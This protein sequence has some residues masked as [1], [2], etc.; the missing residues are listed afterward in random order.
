MYKQEKDAKN[1]IPRGGLLVTTSQPN[2]P[3]ASRPGLQ[4]PLLRQVDS[5][6]EDEEDSNSPKARTRQ[7]SVTTPP[8]SANFI[9]GSTA[10]ARSISTSSGLR[11]N[12][13]TTTRP[14]RTPSVSSPPTAFTAAK[15]SS[16]M[17][18]GRDFKKFNVHDN[19]GF[20]ART[21]VRQR[22][23]DSLDLDDIMNGSD[24]DEEEAPAHQHQKPK[25]HQPITP[26]SPK[27]VGG[28]SSQTRDLMDF[29]AEG[30]PEPPSG[31]GGNDFVDFLAS[32]PPEQIDAKPK[33]TGRLQRMIS[34][35][36]LGNEK[37]KATQ[38]ARTTVPKP[39]LPP[40]VLPTPPR[41][42]NIAGPSTMPLA[43]RPI[44]P[45][46]PRPISPPSSPSM[47]HESSDENKSFR[48]APRRPY[49]DTSLSREASFSTS[50]RTASEKPTAYPISPVSSAGPV[51]REPSEKHIPTDSHTPSG[52]TYTPGSSVSGH[53]Y[54]TPTGSGYATPNNGN[55][56][57]GHVS[58]N[59]VPH[60]QQSGR[61]YHNGSV[62][63]RDRPLKDVLSDSQTIVPARS[64][65]YA[66]PARKP[67][68]SISSSR[69]S[70]APSPPP[71]FAYAPPSTSPTPPVQ[72]GRPNQQHVQLIQPPKPPKSAARVQAPLPPEPA[73][74]VISESDI[75]DM[76]RLL[77][78]AST[79]D[80]CRLIFD[81]YLARNKIPR[82]P[83]VPYP[84]PSPSVVK[85]NTH[86]EKSLETSVVE[87]FLGG[88][89]Q[90]QPS[91]TNTEQASVEGLPKSA[92]APSE[93]SAQYT[94][95]IFTPS[96]AP[97]RHM[98]PIPA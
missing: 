82:E 2:P 41:L 98:A 80:E 14:T 84:S 29:L 27:K 92:L 44:P 22:N 1:T 7:V 70:P 36:N 61:G 45:R 71:A 49:Q 28:V 97:S 19:N 50:E 81:M 26:M 13:L 75:R 16:D 6:N 37:A 68:P 33:G 67:V 91:F 52:N 85:A 43:N 9:P 12:P 78:S 34:K 3:L 93:Q 32:G 74:S 57:P 94:A 40:A 96:P 59:G 38:D 30:P 54:S 88:S 62:N 17:S 47:S 35:L 48:N 73:S 89:R 5:I 4:Q 72:Q 90:Q 42:P 60:G 69:A 64:T 20:P 31:R 15:P 79:A 65:S 86:V 66:S 55:G 58:P 46:P 39:P 77:S 87:L 56:Y 10:R 83:E 76:Q 21:R 24:D 8:P 63:G 95:D 53:G 18:H 25:L 11:N 23:R 51:R